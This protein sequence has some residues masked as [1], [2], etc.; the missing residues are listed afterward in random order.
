M[1][2][3]LIVLAF[4]VL[5]AAI[6]IENGMMQCEAQRIFVDNKHQCVK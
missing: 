4:I 1:L 5:C 3:M 2:D 6:S